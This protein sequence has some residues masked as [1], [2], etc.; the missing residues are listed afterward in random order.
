M[1]DPALGQQAAAELLT[2][3]LSKSTH[4]TTEYFSEEAH[5][6]SSLKHTGIHTN[7]QMYIN[8]MWGDSYQPPFPQKHTQYSEMWTVM[9]AELIDRAHSKTKDEGVEIRSVDSM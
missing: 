8:T 4:S 3:V 2:P 9:H 1:S 5:F 6:S 7:T